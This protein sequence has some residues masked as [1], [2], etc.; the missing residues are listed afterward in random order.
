[1][2]FQ[3]IRNALDHDIWNGSRPI[4]LKIMAL[5]S[6]RNHSVQ[7]GPATGRKFRCCQQFTD[8]SVNRQLPEIRQ[9]W[10]RGW[11]VRQ[12]QLLLLL[13]ELQNLF[14][15]CETWL[16][17]TT[18]QCDCKSRCQK[19][20]RERGTW[21]PTPTG[22]VSLC[23]HRCFR[24]SLTILT[25]GRGGRKRPVP[26]VFRN[27]I[28][29]ATWDLPKATTSPAHQA[30]PVY[31]KISPWY[32]KSKHRGRFSHGRDILAAEYESHFFRKLCQH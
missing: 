10:R 25:L 4:R 19:R 28:P 3:R 11:N 32:L 8:R 17:P 16:R 29:T 12:F 20:P 27:S 6:S 2:T 18:A 26:H 7:S 22:E 23:V 21:R 9:R 13:N 5:I 14:I 24:P 30:R 31:P 15:N 1:M